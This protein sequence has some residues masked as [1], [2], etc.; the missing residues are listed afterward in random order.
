MSRRGRAPSWFDSSMTNCIYGSCEAMCCS[1]CWLCF[2][3]WMTKVSS[4]YLNHRQEVWHRAKGLDIALFH[5][6]VGNKGA[7]RGTHG[8]TMDL[9][10]I[11][12]LKRKYVF[13]RQNFRNVT[14]SGMD[15]LV[16]IVT[17]LHTCT[18]IH[19]EL[20]V[21]MMYWQPSNFVHIYCIVTRG[22]LGLNLDI[23][24]WFKAIS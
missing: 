18:Y 20:Y 13:V 14:I 12:T 16:Q 10:I 24:L 9:F 21:F 4:T 23:I 3:S 22:S 7:N 1:N 6:Q 5:K 15:M 11:L 8:S 17:Y 2:A 19:I